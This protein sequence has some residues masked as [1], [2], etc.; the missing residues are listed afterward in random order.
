MENTKYFEIGNRR[1][2]GSKR[3]LLEFIHE[4]VDENCQDVRSVADLFAGTGVVGYSFNDPSTSV[5]VNDLLLSNYF[6]YLTFF[7]YEAID[8]AKLEK[9]VGFYNGFEP[10]DENYFS[11]NFANTYFSAANARKIGWVR[12]DIERLFKAGDVNERERGVLIT[13]LIYSMDHIA[14]TVGHY[15]AYRRNSDLERPLVIKL[16]KDLPSS[17]ANS[18][19]AIYRE[20]ANELVKKIKVDLV[21]IDPPYNSRQYCD[22]YHLLENVAEWQKPSVHGVA[23]KMDADAAEKSRYCLKSAPEAFEDLVL[24]INARYILVSYN[25]MGSKGAGRSQAKLSDEDISSSLMK[26]GDIFKFETSFRPFSTGKTKISGHTERLFL[27][28][29]Q[30]KN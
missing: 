7:G 23:K 11:I 6:S 4:V 8:M 15:D 10:A 2:L 22:A 1:Y 18:N 9:I 21:Y 20:D 30:P 16:P 13:C 3:K 24:N 5:I 12:D 28:K 27:C 17:E 29:V 14:N 25:N 26:R 19:N